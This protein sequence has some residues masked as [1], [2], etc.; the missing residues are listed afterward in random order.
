[1]KIQH[2]FDPIKLLCTAPSKIVCGLSCFDKEDGHY[3]HPYDCYKYI[4]C[5]D[6]QVK[7]LKCH[8]SMLFDASKLICTSGNSAKCFGEDGMQ[9][10]NIQNK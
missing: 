4:V 5:I 9:F 3:S 2:F 6:N 1:M 10:S 8:L 7:V